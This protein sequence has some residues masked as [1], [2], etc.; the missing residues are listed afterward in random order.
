M[1]TAVGGEAPLLLPA[2]REPLQASGLPGDEQDATPPCRYRGSLPA[3][4]AGLPRLRPQRPGSPPWSTE[5]GNVLLADAITVCDKTK[6]RRKVLKRYVRA[7]AEGQTW[8][9]KSQRTAKTLWATA[10]VRCI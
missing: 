3:T 8:R 2:A 9:Q 5:E 4:C 1:F 7:K 10:V 6:T